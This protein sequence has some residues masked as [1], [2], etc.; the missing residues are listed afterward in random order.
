MKASKLFKVGLVLKTTLLLSLHTHAFQPQKP[1]LN[2]CN[3]KVVGKI[4]KKDESSAP[5]FRRFNGEVMKRLRVLVE[6]RSEL[7]REIANEKLETL[8]AIGDTDFEEDQYYLFSV[9][10]KTICT[11]EL[12]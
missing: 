10:K 7:N 6:V 3:N 1:D 2:K 4:I 11:A 12:I 5:H 9:N 8:V